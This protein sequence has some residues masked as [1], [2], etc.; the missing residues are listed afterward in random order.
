MRGVAA[1]Y[2]T[3]GGGGVARRHRV[4]RLIRVQEKTW[5]IEREVGI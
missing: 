4:D 5:E 3:R 1:G 2:A